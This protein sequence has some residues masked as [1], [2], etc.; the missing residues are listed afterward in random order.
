MLNRNLPHWL[1]LGLLAAI[2]V[3]ALAAYGWIKPYLNGPDLALT[4]IYRPKPVPVK[5][6]TVK[7]MNDVRVVREKVPVP[8]GVE[9]VHDI[10]PKVAKRLVDDFHI[11]LPDLRKEHRELVMLVHW[12]GCS[13]AEASALLQLNPSTARSRYAAAREALRVSLGADPSDQL[14]PPIQAKSADGRATQ[15]GRA[16]VLPQPEVD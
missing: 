5:V 14:T 3:G 16:S 8:G 7:W 12:E 15:L 1:S 11:S 10:P 9:V 6:A 13:L 4:T 2:V